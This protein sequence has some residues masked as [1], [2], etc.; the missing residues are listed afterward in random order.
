MSAKYLTASTN[1]TITEPTRQ[2]K[3]GMEQWMTYH[4]KAIVLHYPIIATKKVCTAGRITVTGSGSNELTEIIKFSGS[5]EASTKYPIGGVIEQKSLIQFFDKSFNSIGPSVQMIDRNSGTFSTGVECY[6]AVLVKYSTQFNILEYYPDFKES[7]EG[8]G[9]GQT[10]GTTTWGTIFSF[11]EKTGAMAELEVT[12]PDF[13]ARNEFEVYTIYSEYVTDENGRHEKPDDWDT[14]EPKYLR[15]P[16][17]EV[18]EKD[19]SRLNQ[20]VYKIGFINPQGTFMWKHVS[21][22]AQNFHPFT[23]M[24]NYHPKYYFQV[25]SMPE[26]PEWVKKA[27]QRLDF[28]RLFEDEK[29]YFDELERK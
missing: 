14:D 15:D 23:G 3:L 9:T 6:G 12:P 13:E 29:Q 27:Y 8:Y 19:G 26:S 1:V 2:P 25:A 7:V 16:Q 5:A 4:N 20:R 21:S 11:D 18:P 10:G 22:T 17:A 24:A 28:N